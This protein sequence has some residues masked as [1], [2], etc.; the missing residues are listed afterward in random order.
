MDLS[1]LAFLP[2]PRISLPG[3]FDVNL[4]ILLRWVHFIAGITWLG[5]LYFFNLVN[6]PFMKEIEGPARS[7]VVTALLPR[8]L[9][10]FR[11]A[12][13]VTVLAGIWYW[14]MIVHTDAHNGQANGGMAIGSFF[15]IWTAV[16]AIEMGM[17]M[18]PAEALKKG[19]VLGVVM[20]V[21]VVVAGYLYL[22]LNSHGWESNHLLSI[23]IGGGLGWFM[24][25]NVWGLIWRA[26]KK[27]IRW[28]NENAA[29][30]T[31]VPAE[32]AKLGRMVFLVSRINFALSF[33][34][35]FFMAAASHYPMFSGQF[36][37]LS[38]R[39]SVG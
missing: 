3:G 28:T 26:Q 11:W 4:Q 8:A 30:G 12:A 32:A 34:M 14:M 38:S 1:A 23:G 24:L 20:G 25:L 18:S 36:S 16:F 27:I 33:P 2:T 39:F 21:S 31:P 19:P 13:V 5:L 6:I 22:A 7:K 9:W 10:W 35:L 17:L 15:A 37:V 29:N